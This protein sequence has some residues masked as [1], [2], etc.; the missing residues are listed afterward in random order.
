M[1][2]SKLG[3]SNRAFNSPLKV[4][5]ALEIAKSPSRL[6]S[7]NEEADKT[8]QD[9]CAEKELILKQISELETKIQEN[10]EQGKAPIHLDILA[11]RQFFPQFLFFNRHELTKIVLEK[12][13]K[14][15]KSCDKPFGLPRYIRIFKTELKLLKITFFSHLQHHRMFVFIKSAYGTD[16][17]TIVHAV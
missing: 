9:S 7:T 4:K 17:P 10:N 16:A 14:I 13:Y 6:A 15:L 8:E 3:K 12:F 5:E 2:K 1:R 11:D